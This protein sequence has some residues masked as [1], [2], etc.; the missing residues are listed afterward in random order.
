MFR[1]DEAVHRFLRICTQLTVNLCHA[2]LAEVGPA[3]SLSRHKSYQ[4]IDAIETLFV[5]IIRHS[6]SNAN[7]SSKIGLIHKVRNSTLA[8]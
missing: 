8:R 6:S 1:T 4:T 5:M 3:G 2:H 7:A